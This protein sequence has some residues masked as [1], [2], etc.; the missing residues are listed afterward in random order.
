MVE[1]P[2]L[3]LGVAAS[4]HHLCPQQVG[5]AYRKKIR[6]SWRPINSKTQGPQHQGELGT[7]AGPGW[8]GKLPHE[9][10]RTHSFSTFLASPH[11]VALRWSSLTH[12]EAQ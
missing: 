8:V 1:I 4:Q 12:K 7:G 2:L 6:I 9:A 11:K 3:I 10:C 5:N